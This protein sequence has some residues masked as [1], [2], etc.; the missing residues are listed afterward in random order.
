VD[1][2][3]HPRGDLTAFGAVLFGDAASK[4]RRDMAMAA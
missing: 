2:E 1:A 3:L 4:H